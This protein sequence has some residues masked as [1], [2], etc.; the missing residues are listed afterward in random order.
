MKILILYFSGTGNTY[1]CAKYLGER[2]SRSGNAIDLYSVEDFPCE[3]AAQYDFLIAGFPVYAGNMPAIVRDCLGALPPAGTGR[4]GLFCTKALCSGNALRK[5]SRLLAASGSRIVGCA[6]VTMPGSDGLAFLPADSAFAKKMC[7]RDFSHIRPLDRLAE[8]I[9]RD[10]RAG[11]FPLVRMRTRPS[12]VVMD[13]SFKLCYAPVSRWIQKKFRADAHCVRCGLCE[14]ICPA[15]NIRVTEN[16]V[17]F[18]GRC[19]LCM[20][21][22]HQ[23]PQA[24]IQIGRGT[25]GKTRWQGPAG[26]YHPLGRNER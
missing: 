22:I 18:G 17:A 6:D 20:R 13:L 16:G 12:G 8:K 2:L 15:R 25:V 11:D 7:G 19:M 23:C 26:C 3:Q 1:Y 4:A 24:A 9:E 10:G 21:C 5:A 14:R